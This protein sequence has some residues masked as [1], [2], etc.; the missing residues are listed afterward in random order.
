MQKLTFQ[1]SVSPTLAAIVTTMFSLCIRIIRLNTRP[2]IPFLS[3]KLFHILENAFHF[4]AVIN[5]R[6]LKYQHC[7]EIPRKLLGIPGRTNTVYNLLSHNL[8]F[9]QVATIIWQ[10][11]NWQHFYCQVHKSADNKGLCASSLVISLKFLEKLFN[12]TKW[13]A[14]F[15]SCMFEK[16]KPRNPHQ[17]GWINSIKTA[18]NM[19]FLQ[20]SKTEDMM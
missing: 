6:A 16:T 8:I 15:D 17:S 5:V 2:S 13:Q 4:L 1:R 7:C 19:P 10:E 11:I 20:F 9:H 14:Q 12:C 18:K 3:R